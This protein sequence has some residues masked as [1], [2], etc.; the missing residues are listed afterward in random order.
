MQI[1][2]GRKLLRYPCNLGYSTARCKGWG[3]RC[4][5]SSHP[6]EKMTVFAD[7]LEDNTAEQEGASGQGRTKARFLTSAHF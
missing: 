6:A 7:G 5:D 3:C 1:G 2:Q 4:S